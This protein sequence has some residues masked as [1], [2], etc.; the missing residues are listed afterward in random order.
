[1][2]ALFKV[3]TMPARYYT[4]CKIRKPPTV[5]QVFY[6]VDKQVHGS[7]QFRVRLDE[8]R[9]HLSGGDIYFVESW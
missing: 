6:I 9:A 1:M 5:G 4:T 7:K 3:G 8:I 2:R